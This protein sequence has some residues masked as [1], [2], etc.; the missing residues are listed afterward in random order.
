MNF[1]NFVALKTNLQKRGC[2]SFQSFELDGDSKFYL[3][4]KGKLGEHLT[5]FTLIC[6]YAASVLT[7]HSLLSLVEGAQYNLTLANNLL[8]TKKTLNG[9]E[10]IFLRPLYIS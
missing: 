10:G 1:N 6:P 8:I 4:I 7:P 2:G 5:L 3:A 9:V